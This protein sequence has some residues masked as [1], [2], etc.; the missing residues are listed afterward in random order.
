MKIHI[1]HPAL[2]KIVEETPQGDR[3]I[4]DNLSSL[5]EGRI[6]SD[7]IFPI[8]HATVLKVTTLPNITYRFIITPKVIM[9]QYLNDLTDVNVPAPTDGYLL[10]W[11][12][13]AGKWQAKAVSASKIADADGDTKVDVEQSP[14]EDKIRMHVKGVE[15]FM[16]HDDGILDL[17]KQ[18]GASVK[19]D[20]TQ[21]IPHAIWAKCLLNS[22]YFDR[23]NEF[24]ATTNYHFKAKK[25][26]VYFLTG[27]VG[28]SPNTTGRRIAKFMKNTASLTATEQEIAIP[29]NWVFC[30]ATL[31]AL[32]EL[33]TDDEITLCCYQTSGAALNTLA[34]YV[35]AHIWKVG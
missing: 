4:L 29:G 18:S 16:L 19:R 9:I 5:E 3:V 32:V 7:V 15:A 13:T 11:D 1:H 33:V 27:Q 21:S 25:P 12:A 22:K 2:L 35:S 20:A 28:W 31:P 6:E 24:D 8:D 30:Q 17:A 23:Q 26:G 34:N 10:Y 14:D